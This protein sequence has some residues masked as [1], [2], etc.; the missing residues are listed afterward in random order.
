MSHGNSPQI[1][2]EM[3][4]SRNVSYIAEQSDA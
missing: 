2:P 4:R 3:D 1:R